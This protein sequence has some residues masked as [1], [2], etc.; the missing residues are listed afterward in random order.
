MPARCSVSP[1]VGSQL[2]R[3]RVEGIRANGHSRGI[4]DVPSIQEE[5]HE[6]MV[7]GGMCPRSARRARRGRAA[8]PATRRRSRYRRSRRRVTP[9]PAARAGQAPTQRVAYQTAP[10]PP[11]VPAPPAV[12]AAAGGP[13]RRADGPDHAVGGHARDP[14]A[15]PLG[16]DG[17]P[18]RA[19]PHQHRPLAPQVRARGRRRRADRGRRGGRLRHP[20][21]GPPRPRPRSRPRRTRPSS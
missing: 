1:V 8:S 13:A 14:R 4:V 6:I 20:G 5:C 7:R 21:R 12:P 16:H 15:R 3:A 17:R 18:D 19:A 10:T 11:T 9:R 2:D